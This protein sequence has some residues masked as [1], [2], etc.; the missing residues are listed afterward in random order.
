MAKT[1]Y[2]CPLQKKKV[3]FKVNSVVKNE[4]EKIN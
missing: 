2:V 4:F 3:W 1:A